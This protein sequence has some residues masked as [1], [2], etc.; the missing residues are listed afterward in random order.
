MLRSWEWTGFF[1]VFIPLPWKDYADGIFF[2]VPCTCRHLGSSCS[3]LFSL[4]SA[5][6]NG[7]RGCYRWQLKI[8]VVLSSS[9]QPALE[10]SWHKG[11][12][13]DSWLLW[14]FRSWWAQEVNWNE[15]P[16]SSVPSRFKT[17]ILHSTWNTFFQWQFWKFGVASDQ[18]LSNL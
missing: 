3:C 18:E 9:L 16:I 1:T 5:V 8:H 7:Q 11:L 17:L 13:T 4:H 14:K 10:F 15:E 6:A 12:L 2:L